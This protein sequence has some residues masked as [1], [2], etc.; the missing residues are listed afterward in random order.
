M[1]TK[2]VF[3]YIFIVLAV[4]L[5]IA[6][7]GL[8]KSF[9]VDVISFFAIFTGRLDAYQIGVVMGSLLYWVMHISAIFLLW[10][11]GRRW[12]SKTAVS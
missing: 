5:V 1:N 12:T 10:K 4:L 11:Y 6:L 9:A 8:L 2:K 7:L 3:G